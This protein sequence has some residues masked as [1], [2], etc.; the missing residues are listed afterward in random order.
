M[1]KVLF[2]GILFILALTLVACNP[3]PVE[4]VYRKE[5]RF[6]STLNVPVAFLAVEWGGKLRGSGSAWLIDGGNGVLFTAKHVTDALMNN[7]IELGA[8]ECKLFLGNGRVFTCITVRVPP[9]RDAVV[10][11]LLE[12]FNL[13]GQVYYFHRAFLHLFSMW[14]N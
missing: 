4:N 2:G 9:L 1:S 10:L 8:N 14:Q 3:P 13:E 12:K 11:R 6:P 5:M 7:Q